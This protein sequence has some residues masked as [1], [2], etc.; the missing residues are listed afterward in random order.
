M[1]AKCGPAHKHMGNG[2]SKMDRAIIRRAGDQTVVGPRR[3]FDQ[4]RP[5]ASERTS[6]GPANN[7]AASDAAPSPEFNSFLPSTSTLRDTVTRYYGIIG[8]FVTIDSPL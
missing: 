5:L 7:P 1:R 3:V 4:S 2:E 8:Q 6:P